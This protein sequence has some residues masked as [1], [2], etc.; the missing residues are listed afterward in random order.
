MAARERYT[1]HTIWVTE[2]VERTGDLL[3]VPTAIAGLLTV[4][5][6]PY[7]LTA[8]FVLMV[9]GARTVTFVVIQTL[10]AT[11]AV[12]GPV[13]I[14]HYDEHVFP[15][16][17]SEVGDV[18]VDDRT[19]IATVERYEQFFCDRYWLIAAVWTVL[20]VAALVANVD[21][22]V[23]FGVTGPADPAFL[24]YLVFALWWSII[25]GIGLHG[26]LTTVLCVRA[27]GDLDLTIDPL[28][29]DGLG[30]LSTIG[31]FSIRATLMNSVGSFALPLAFSIAAGGRFQ[32]L[33]YVAVAGYI[34]FILVSFVYPTIYVNRRAQEVRERVLKE[35]RERIRDLQARAATSDAG[36]ELDGLETQLKIR[37]LRDDFH[38]YRNVNLYPLSV[39]I[40]VRLGSSVLLPILFT[41]ID[42]YVFTA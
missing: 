14:W 9:P 38:E 34:G 6:L 20:I 36:G 26:A 39:S 22:F 16:F 11:V 28:H 42:T 21:Y 33:V 41:L 15:T 7:V 30:G 13:F 2:L 19:L 40:L 18:V 29:H 37:T 27:V 31:Y 24:T 10:A 8:A 5:L 35:K 25:T 32:N 4:G 17:I 12:V 23:S 3:P 1:G